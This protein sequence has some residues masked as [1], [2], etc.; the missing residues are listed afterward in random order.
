MTEKEKLIDQNIKLK[1]QIFDLTRQLDEIMGRDQNRKKKFG[2]KEGEDDQV[3]KAKKLELKKEQLEVMSLK[4]KI[5]IIKRQLESVYNNR[6]LLAKEDELKYLKTELENLEQEK[7]SLLKIKQDQNRALK[8]IKNEEEYEEKID[9]LKRELHCVKEETKG[10]NEKLIESERI[11]R[12]NH[13]QF[14]L[15]QTKVK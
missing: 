12:K 10:L 3:T 5:H 7:K 6:T 15:K 1:T 13:E 8:I 4:N 11:L 14:I 2:I 9:E